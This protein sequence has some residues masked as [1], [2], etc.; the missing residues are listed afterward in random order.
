[1]QKTYFFRKKS[2]LMK[3]QTHNFSINSICGQTKFS[4]SMCAFNI[5]GTKAAAAAAKTKN[6]LSFS[7]SV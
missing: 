4:F 1:M 3:V 6:T 5:M 2:D 7:L